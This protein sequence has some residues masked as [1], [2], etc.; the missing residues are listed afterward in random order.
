MTRFP[1]RLVPQDNNIGQRNVAPVPGGG[2]SGLTDE[3]RGW[4]FEVKNPLTTAATIQIEATLPALLV[5]RD[6]KLDFTNRGGKAFKLEPGQSLEVVM[7]LNRGAEFTPA[8]VAKAE[9]KTIQVAAR[10]NGILI[11]GM[12]YELDP[13]LVHPNRPGAHG[14]P[15]HDHDGHARGSHGEVVID[16]I[17]ETLLRKLLARKQRVRD[18][19]VRKVIL[20]IEMEDC[21]D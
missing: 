16:T 20:E 18:V 11:G 13:K 3:F 17:A 2:T 6:W 7:R 9:Q 12:S 14:E 4:S 10:A 19:E 8:D 1:W 5:Q 15:G 21:D